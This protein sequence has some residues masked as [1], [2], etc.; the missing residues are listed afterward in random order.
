MYTCVEGE[1]GVLTKASCRIMASKHSAVQCGLV[2]EAKEP[3]RTQ[4]S[5]SHANAH[6]HVTSTE[7]TVVLIR[8]MPHGTANRIRLAVIV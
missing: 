8:F 2:V 4:A 7:Q 5:T 3:D 6:A 1:R